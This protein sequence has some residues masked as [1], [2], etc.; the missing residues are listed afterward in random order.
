MISNRRWQA[1][2]E[3]RRLGLTESVQLLGPL[4]QD[5]VRKRMQHS[6]CFVLPCVQ[7]ADGNVDALPT[8][9][10]EAQ[11]CGC[12]VISTRISGVP[13]IIEDGVQGYVIDSPHDIGLLRQSMERLADV[14][15]RARFSA[16]ASKLGPRLT[17]QTHTEQIINLYR[18]LVKR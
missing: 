12:P 6:A 17:M 7:A 11:A 9:L 14:D 5:R 8:V 16:A 4:R 1:R 15:E 13:E 10:L 2:N 18:D 3:I